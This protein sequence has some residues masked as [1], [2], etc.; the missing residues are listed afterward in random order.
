MEGLSKKKKGLIDMD[1]SVVIVARGGGIRGLNEN[2]KNT[3]KKEKGIEI[4]F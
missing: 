4:L 3:I 2:G 1:S